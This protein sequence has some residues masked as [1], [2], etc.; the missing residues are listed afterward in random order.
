MGMKLTTAVRHLLNA[1]PGYKGWVFRRSVRHLTR[2]RKQLL[3]H[4]QVKPEYAQAPVITD[5]MYSDG[6]RQVLAYYNRELETLRSER[7]KKQ[8][9]L[10]TTATNHR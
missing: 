3:A 7:G 1:I 5:A 4:A 6:V 9:S 10:S 2:A 8:S